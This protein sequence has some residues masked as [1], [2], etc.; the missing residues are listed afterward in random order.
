MFQPNKE[1]QKALSG[2]PPS[3]KSITDKQRILMNFHY[4]YKAVENG[5]TRKEILEKLN[6]ELKKIGR[7]EISYASFTKN[8]SD[9]L[10]DEDVTKAARREMRKL[11]KQETRAPAQE[12]KVKPKAKLMSAT[13]QEPIAVNVKIKPIDF[14]SKEPSSASK[15]TQG[16][17]SNYAK[18]IEWKEMVHMAKR[19]NWTRDE[20]AFAINEGLIKSGETPVH[21]NTLKAYITAMG[22]GIDDPKPKRGPSI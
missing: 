9:L 20:I 12:E 2:P 16:K 6:K 4:I 1:I 14:S 11:D 22:T 15:V 8:V 17:R 19:A 13:G 10:G 21:L 18:A 7:P 3:E 5:W